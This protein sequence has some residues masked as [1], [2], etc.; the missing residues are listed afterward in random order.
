MWQRTA[1]RARCVEGLP[2]Y[3]LSRPIS[4]AFSL[5]VCFYMMVAVSIQVGAGYVVTAGSEYKGEALA[6]KE[7]V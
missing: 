1:P 2:G 3:T 5:S 6:K 4:F 7:K